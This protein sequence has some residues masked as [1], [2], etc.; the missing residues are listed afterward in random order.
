MNRT[1][2]G[3]IYWNG[4]PAWDTQGFGTCRNQSAQ[5]QDLSDP[6]KAKAVGSIGRQ[7]LATHL[8]HVCPLWEKTP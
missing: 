4:L 6:E 7:W 8:S 1:C 5:I 3:C 2:S